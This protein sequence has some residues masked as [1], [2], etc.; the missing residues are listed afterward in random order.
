MHIGYIQD[1]GNYERYESDVPLRN[2]DGTIVYSRDLNGNLV[3]VYAH[4]KGEIVVDSSGRFVYKRAKVDINAI[5]VNPLT[6]MQYAIDRMS[7]HI[8]EQLHEYVSKKFAERRKPKCMIGI[9]SIPTHMGLST[10]T[11]GQPK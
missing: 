3:M 11:V 5:Q 1:L 2:A 7:D 9:N 8:L 10:T 6:Y 4:R